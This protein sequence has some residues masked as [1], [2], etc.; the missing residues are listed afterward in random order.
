M[1]YNAKS[2]LHGWWHGWY[3]LVDSVNGIFQLGQRIVVH[4]KSL[5]ISANCK[6]LMRGHLLYGLTVTILPGDF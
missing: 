5:N 1:F 2:V 6:L 4:R 3:V